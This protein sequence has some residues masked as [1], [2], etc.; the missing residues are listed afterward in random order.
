MFA[1]FL[2][3]EIDDKVVVDDPFSLDQLREI[4]N[5]GQKYDIQFIL[6]GFILIHLDQR[7]IE[8]FKKYRDE[9][10]HKHYRILDYDY[11]YQ[12]SSQSNF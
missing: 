4:F 12:E 5:I 3:L 11:P 9:S 1:W 10:D 2:Y 8:E 6:E 7:W